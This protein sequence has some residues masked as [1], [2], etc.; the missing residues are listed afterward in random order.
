MS[1]GMEFIKRLILQKQ[2]LI[3]S[4]CSEHQEKIL[5]GIKLSL[6]ENTLLV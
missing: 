5:V 3:A 4:I 6:H 1:E 2:I